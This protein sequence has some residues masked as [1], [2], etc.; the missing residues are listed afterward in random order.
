MMSSR[1]SAKFWRDAMT[2]RRYK[3]VFS[4]DGLRRGEIFFG[5]VAVGLLFLFP[6]GD[7]LRGKEAV[8]AES[9][10]EMTDA[11]P[12]MIPHFNGRRID[13]LS[14]PLLW[15]GGKAGA[16]FGVND[17]SLHLM[18]IFGALLFLCGS[19]LLCRAFFGRKSALLTGFLLLGNGVFLHCAHTFDGSTIAAACG[20]LAL[21]ALFCDVPKR[22][23]FRPALFFF[24]LLSAALFGSWRSVAMRMATAFFLALSRRKS[25]RENFSKRRLFF[26]CVC[27]VAATAGAFLLQRRG[28][29]AP[30]PDSWS[31]AEKWADAARD[32]SL[33]TLFPWTIW[34]VAAWL[35]QLFSL[36]RLDVTRKSFLA[37]CG[38]LGLIAIP[39]DLIGGLGATLPFIATAMISTAA[40]LTGDENGG[41]VFSDS[42]IDLV[43]RWLVLL[44]AAVAFA[45]FV[46]LP[47]W[48][49][50]FGAPLP[51]ARV[52][53]VPAAGFL[54]LALLLFE[55]PCA[56]FTALP[57]RCGATVLAALF[58]SATALY[59]LRPA[60][61]YPRAGRDFAVARIRPRLKKLS[62]DA[63]LY[64]GRPADG[65]TL[66]YGE[67]AIP[68]TEITGNDRVQQLFAFLERNRGGDVAV[69][70]PDE[71]IFLAEIERTGRDF[72]MDWS[73]P[74]CGT[75]PS[76]DETPAGIALFSGTV[77]RKATP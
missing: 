10:R 38:A 15:A 52:A 56:E 32:I 71:D 44:V 21:A 48:E 60:F 25:I 51:T 1:R 77:Q 4:L 30:L 54:A 13:G 53:L 3:R 29:L 18:S 12:Q 6:G 39:A 76:A 19:M 67:A 68:A 9:V 64:Y 49:S 31:D 16:F 66:F 11:D 5:I 22:S 35:L 58:L 40:A 42:R 72:G 74:E 36:S 70:A 2:A 14:L 69:I 59:A 28:I 43:V 8:F 20:M 47:A 75:I 63:I 41:N 55:R 50:I 46:I 45:S 61:S 17:F 27:A 24:L 23:F 62:A 26:W 34:A 73:K 33:R 65:F 7:A 57:R 37:A